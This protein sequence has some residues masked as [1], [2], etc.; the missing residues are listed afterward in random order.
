MEHHW[1]S[2]RGGDDLVVDNDVERHPGWPIMPSEYDVASPHVRACIKRC[3]LCDSNIP[4]K[5]WVAAKKARTM[6]YV[7]NMPS[8][9]FR[10]WLNSNLSQCDF[11]SSS[12]TMPLSVCLRHIVDWRKERSAK[13]EPL[14]AAAK[15]RVDISAA[16]AAQCRHCDGTR[17]WVCQR[18]DASTF[19]FPKKIEPN[20]APS[21]Q[22]SVEGHRRRSWRHD[23]RHP[24]DTMSTDDILA[25]RQT[26]NLSA[27]SAA[28]GSAVFTERGIASPPEWR[29]R[30]D[31]TARNKLFADFF[32]TE[33]ISTKLAP[34]DGAA[35][36]CTQLS[37]F[38]QVIIF[39][40]GKITSD[41]SIFRISADGGQGDLKITLQIVYSDDSVFTATT[42]ADRTASGD[43]LDAG[44][45]RTFI[46]AL[47]NGAS[48]SYE[49]L[50]FLFDSLD[51]ASVRQLLPTALFVLVIDMKL[52]NI[53]IGIGGVGSRYSYLYTLWSSF[54][55]HSQPQQ[56][57]TID[58]II[59]QNN[60][61]REHELKT[62]DNDCFKEFQSVHHAP[63][64][65]LQLFKD[66][67]L[68]DFIVP[69]QLHLILGIIKLLY[70]DLVVL[71]PDLAAAWLAKLGVRHDDRHGRSGF[72][73]N[74]SRKLAAGSEKLA[75]F[76]PAPSS[77]ESS[78]ASTLRQHVS[79]II[80]ALSAFD[81]VIHH[82]MS[83]HLHPLWRE[84]ITNFQSAYAD[85]AKTMNKVNPMAAHRRDDRVTPKLRCIFEE[86]P[87]W[88]DRHKTSL[89]R[90]SEQSFESIHHKFKVFVSDWAI[91]VTGP[92]LESQYRKRKRKLQ[93]TDTR[94]TPS[95]GTR[96][97]G[98]VQRKRQRVAQVTSDKNRFSFAAGF[99]L[100]AVGG[101]T[102]GK[103]GKTTGAPQ[104]IGNINVAR[105]RRLHSLLAFNFLALPSDMFSQKK[106]SDILTWRSKNTSGK[107]PWTDTAQVS[108]IN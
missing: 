35:Y 81:S 64:K 51:W 3:V 82:T 20:E 23:R 41:V 95:D 14:L 2:G 47:M 31:A 68:P 52:A 97:G 108:I 48:E 24:G 9:T 93:E 89:L 67:Y 91:P 53:I 78:A 76:I 18:G 5:I 43:S 21:E 59:E 65:L 99:R 54:A 101:S 83:L 56:R 8:N 75:A 17:C 10:Q 79:T 19:T 46:V 105:K 7:P 66:V 100:K 106:I 104:I 13:L 92:A 22:K 90:I 39:I 34:N 71:D 4:F 37:T 32:S 12:P 85:V 86:V 73:G 96:S 38:V 87:A 25:H 72:V 30:R 11:S 69:A 36:L 58:N 70:D 27:R 55:N 98:A 88:I 84:S 94:H 62:G 15:S 50:S 16:E 103:S 45:N 40:R 26:T 49:T 6:L 107:P 28:R 57:R 102:G 29:V 42:R 60:L 1:S 63:I 33:F 77:N 61:R 80:N 44:V 74:D